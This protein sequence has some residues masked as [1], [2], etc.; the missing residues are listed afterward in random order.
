M[1]INTTKEN[2]EGF[3]LIFVLVFIA[4]IMGIAAEIVYLTTIAARES[5][6][7]ENTLQAEAT[8][9]TGMEFAKLLLTFNKISAG[10]QNNPAIPL[11]KDLFSV[12]N[13]QPI[14]IEGLEDAKN[15]SGID[16]SKA[17]APEILVGLQSIKGYFVLN[18]TSE[19][20]KFNLNWLQGSSSDT[21]QK[22]LLR[23]FSTPDTQK[24][25]DLYGYTPQE[26]VSDLV[27]YIKISQDSSTSM[28][29]EPDYTSIGATYK[30]KH[31]ALES[32][33]ELRRIPKFN[34]DTIYDV[35]AP[36]F[37]IWPISAPNGTLNINAAPVELIAAMM[38][39]A[40]QD[41]VEKDLDQFE[42][43]RSQNAFDKNK[44]NSWFASHFSNYS[45][46][47]DSEDIQNTFFG[48]SD[49]VF[50]VESRGV[51]NGI[52][53]KWVVVL[54]PS[55]SSSSRNSPTTANPS[56]STNPNQPIDSNQRPS[57]GNTAPGQNPTNNGKTAISSPNQ[58][59]PFQ[60]LYSQWE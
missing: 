17:I 58:S 57:N 44:L 39:P 14:G 56:N 32:L 49:T 15:L 9:Q 52:E 33:Q 10:Y 30:P 34:I 16:F 4:A 55:S 38:T 1:A 18:I 7:E 36:Y 28:Q 3:A 48:T 35:F 20:T 60:I 31:A 13:G 37:T 11:P 54:A 22:A 50:R 41:L 40:G 19:N 12:L 2:E 8:A 27:S 45:D 25:L 26:V 6:N 51:V 42:D 5:M 46:N 53:R 24:F 29:T 23:I 21:A 43:E 59:Q 47:K